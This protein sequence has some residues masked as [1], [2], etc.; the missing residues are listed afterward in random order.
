[1]TLIASARGESSQ[2]SSKPLTHL[3]LTWAPET[4]RKGDKILKVDLFRHTISSG[5]GLP[6]YAQARIIDMISTQLKKHRYSPCLWVTVDAPGSWYLN[7][8]KR[9]VRY[10]IPTIILA[11]DQDLYDYGDFRCKGYCPLLS[12]FEEEDFYEA[13]VS[14]PFSFADYGLSKESVVRVLRILAHLKTAHTK[15]ITSLAGY[16]KTYVRNLLKELQSRGLIEWKHIG[17][18]D[19]WAIKTRGMRL[20]HRSWN[21]PKG[22]HFTQ[23]RGEVRYSGERHRRVSRMWRA[24][25]EAAYPY[26]EIWECWTE[27][28][29]RR[30]IPDGLAWGHRD[31]KEILFWLEVDSGHSSR[32]VMARQYNRRLQLAMDHAYERRITI[33]FCIM[34]PPWVVKEFAW[35]L[36]SYSLR[37]Y[38]FAVIGHD[39]RDFGRLPTYE[40]GRYLDDLDVTRYRRWATS[41]GREGLSFDPTQYPR[42]YKKKKS[43]RQTKQKSNKSRYTSPNYDEEIPWES[44]PNDR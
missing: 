35:N 31:G 19:G 21:V 11:P 6:S 44:D 42:R 9:L 2:I 34:G 12:L 41:V 24:W 26:I 5:D 22:A 28:Q 13:H 7:E 29:M 43:P 27:V 8:I 14:P 18:Y 3:N 23:Y 10:I 25:L 20:A 15:E 32:Q 4:V 33:V 1:M 30:G 16:S 40:A 38:N 36:G 37:Q 17:K 39:W